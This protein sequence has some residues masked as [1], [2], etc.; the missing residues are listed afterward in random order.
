MMTSMP[1]LCKNATETISAV[2]SEIFIVL[3][4][5]K[6]SKELNIEFAFNGF[7]EYK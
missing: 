3:D 1:V 7:D 2:I 5:E 4:L 6:L